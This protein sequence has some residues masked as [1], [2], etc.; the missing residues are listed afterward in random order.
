MKPL[1]ILLHGLARG[2]GSMAGLSKHLRA[3]GFDTW[4]TTYPSRQ[5]SI[6]Y[7]ASALTER[8]RMPT[9]SLLST[10]SVAQQA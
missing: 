2:H 5:H 3:R 1:V 9:A 10:L 7:L 6:A 4:S 8:T